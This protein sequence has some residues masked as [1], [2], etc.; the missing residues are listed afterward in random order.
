[1][2]SNLK[3]R[4]KIL[5]LSIIMILLLVSISGVGYYYN[6]KGNNGIKAMYNDKLLPVQWLNDNRAQAR[7]IEADLYYIILNPENKEE[8][9]LKLNDI[10][11]R[12]KI[13]D[14]QFKLYKKAKLDKFELDKIQTIENDLEKYRGGRD[15]T[16]EL[17]MNGKQKEALVK[18][19]S[20]KNSADEFQ[21]NLKELGEYNSKEAE[22]ISIQN[23]N[24]FNSS[25]KIFVGISIVSIIIGIILS[26]AISRSIV[27]PLNAAVE[28]IKR[29]AQKDFTGV[30][31]ESFFRRKDEIGV[32]ANAIYTMQADIGILIKELI[33]ESQNMSSASEELSATIEELNVKS[34]D[35]QKAVNKIAYDVQETS[36]ASEEISA[37]MQEVDSSINMLSS[38]AMEGSN[39]SYE[40]KERAKYIQRKGNSSIQ[41]TKNIYEE[42]KEKGLKALEEGKVVENIKVMADTIASISEE[43]NLLALNAAIEA[44]RAGEQGKGFAVVAEEV[45]KLAEGSSTAVSNI[46]DTIVKVQHAFNNLSSNSREVLDFIRDHVDPQFEVMKATGEQ[47]YADAEF[48]NNMSEEIASMSEELTATMAQINESV[49]NTAET[50]QKS[51]ENIETIKDSVD[52]STKAISQIAVVA[53][54]QAEMAE[55]LS[56]IAQKFKI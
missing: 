22:N 42:K 47:Y 45:K 54:E 8:Q 50:A 10:K 37:S 21:K 14:E 52:E 1:M 40:S 17:A 43:T 4:S 33:D 34:E 18:Y 53:Q 6:L 3:T 51:S 2:L 44:A 12:A 23:I 7:A 35:I 19:N 13:F 48:V 38:K 25:I 36:A 27:K 15:D 26:I 28:Y 29:L 55:K 41:E 30:I 20:I 24:D 39:N 16:I 32:L 49:Q 56:E 5:L 46:Q 9:N 31:H 11:E